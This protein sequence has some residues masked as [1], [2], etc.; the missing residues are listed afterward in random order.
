VRVKRNS[1]AALFT[2][3]DNGCGFDTSRIHSLDDPHRG[4]G[5]A[6]ME[7]RVR[8]QGGALEIISRENQ[9]TRIA[10]TLPLGSGRA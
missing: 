3:E 2:V 5:L 4:L 8:M 1:T 9:G 6:A 10:F 7:E